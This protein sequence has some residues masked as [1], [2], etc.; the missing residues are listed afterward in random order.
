MII[1]TYYFWQDTSKPKPVFYEVP[2]Y[3]MLVHTCGACNTV[4][5]L[6]LCYTGTVKRF[7]KYMLEQSVSVRAVPE[8]IEGQAGT[9]VELFGKAL[10]LFCIKVARQC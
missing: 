1:L 8:S 10:S 9:A 5:T 3:F 2:I 6:N 7:G 4:L